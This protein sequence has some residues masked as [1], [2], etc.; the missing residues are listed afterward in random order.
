M[1]FDETLWQRLIHGGCSFREALEPPQK[2]LCRND[3]NVAGICSRACC[4]LANSQYATVIE[5]E[6]VLHLYVK[7]PERAHLVKKLWEKFKLSKSLL[8]ALQQ[9]DERMEHWSSHQVN[10][11]KQRVTKL[12]QMLASTRDIAVQEAKGKSTKYVPIKKKTE[13]RPAA[14]DEERIQQGRPCG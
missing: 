12:L 2:S 14:L 6:G 8:R 9:V 4:P 5:N 13:R 1:A 3:Y 10:R 7:T 11:V